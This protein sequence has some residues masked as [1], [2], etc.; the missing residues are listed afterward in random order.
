M[1]AKIVGIGGYIPPK[2][3]NNEYLASVTETSDEWIVQRTGI[4]ERRILEDGLGTSDMIVKAIE[5]LLLKYEVALDDI[6]ALIVAT[7]TP[8]MPMP[9]TSAIVCGKLN[10]KG[11]FGFDINSACSG[12]IYALDIAASLIESGRFKNIIVA[13]ADAMSRVTDINDRS[14]NILFGDGAGVVLVQPTPS[15]KGIIDV[16]VD[17]NGEG[18]DHLH[19]QGGGSLHPLSAEVLNG[20]TNC[21]K[22]NGKVVFKNA[23]EKMTF[24]CEKI[25]ERNNLSPDEVDWLIPHQANYR[26]IDAVGNHLK[27]APQK[28]L[29][30]VESVGNTTAASI[31]LCLWQFQERL[32]T[33]DTLLL[34]AFG[35]GFTWGSAL[36]EWSPNSKKDTQ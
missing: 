17:G 22:Q 30:N 10:A 1:K 5:D 6:D 28:V 31:P 19:I 14:T 35:A 3:R 2:I 26:I 15:D 9:S 21:I 27:I 25:L 23:V 32:K 18:Q 34:V 24:A 11:I 16:Y 33:G 4:K 8:D 29:S 7:C 36:I 13:G 20:K 12:F